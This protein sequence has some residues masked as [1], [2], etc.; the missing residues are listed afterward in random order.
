MMRKNERLKLRQASRDTMRSS[1]ALVELSS[2]RSS[3]KW[4]ICY[5]QDHQQ[6]DGGYGKHQ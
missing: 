1:R 6:H 3:R 2:L 5:Q 4:W